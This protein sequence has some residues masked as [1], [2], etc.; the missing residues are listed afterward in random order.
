M[1]A[2]SSRHAARQQVVTQA[3]QVTSCAEEQLGRVDRLVSLGQQ[4]LAAGSAA[5]M[6]PLVEELDRLTD[7]VLEAPAAQEAGACSLEDAKNYLDSL[8]LQLA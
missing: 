2:F 3:Q 7:I 5:E 1:R 8:A 6:E 4:A